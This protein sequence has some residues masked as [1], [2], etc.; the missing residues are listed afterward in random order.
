MRR[1]AILNPE[2]LED[3]THPSVFGTAWPHADRLTF[4]FAPDGARVAGQSQDPLGA[5]QPSAL[6][7]EMAAAGSVRMAASPLPRPVPV[8]AK[9]GRSSTVKTRRSSIASRAARRTLRQPIACPRRAWRRSARSSTNTA[10][11][12]V[13]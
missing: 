13:W 5:G 2:R 10:A 9:P 3:R 4:S 12:A 1:R 11:G 6:S 8:L 7:S